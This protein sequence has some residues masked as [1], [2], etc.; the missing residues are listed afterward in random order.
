MAIAQAMCSSFKPELLGG[1]HDL[2]TDAI[3]IALYT[4]SATLGAATTAYTTTNEVATAGGYTAGGIQLT[5]PVI[6]LD[7]TTGICDFADATWP[8]ATIT[9]RGALIYNSS[10]SNK[11]IAVLDFGSDK[12]STA[13]AFSVIMPAA[14]AATAIVRIA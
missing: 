14:A 8:A 1:I 9:A 5:S 2:D 6:T 12:T 10:K 3:F 13:G 7:G 11:A 4:S